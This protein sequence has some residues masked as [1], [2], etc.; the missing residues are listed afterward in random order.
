MIIVDD[1]LATGGT[2]RAAET[3][4]QRVGANVLVGVVVIELPDLGG[5]KKLEAPVESLIRFE[6]D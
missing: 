3:L 5:R 6:G 1:L 4:L 2:M